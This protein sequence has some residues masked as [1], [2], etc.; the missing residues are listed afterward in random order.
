MIKTLILERYQCAD[1]GRLFYIDPKDT[2]NYMID[3]GCPYGC[4]DAGTDTTRIE[5]KIISMPKKYILKCYVPAG[6]GWRFKT[7]N[8]AEAEKEHQELMQPE[9]IYKIEEIEKE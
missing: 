3:F 8:G 1:C 5:V 6:D 7:K 4:D 2:G 9:N